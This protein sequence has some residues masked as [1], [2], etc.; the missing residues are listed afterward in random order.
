M[1]IVQKYAKVL[2][3]GLLCMVIGGTAGFRSIKTVKAQCS[4]SQGYGKNYR[5]LT[6]SPCAQCKGIDYAWCTSETCQSTGTCTGLVGTATT[7]CVVGGCLNGVSGNCQ[8][9]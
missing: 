8:C 9:L 6:G 2:A 3:V 5:C 1:R 7:E 4:V